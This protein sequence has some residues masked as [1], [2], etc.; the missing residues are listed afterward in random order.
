MTPTQWRR[1]Q[2]AVD[3][4]IV[5]PNMDQTT[6]YA[7]WRSNA[8]QD[9]VRSAQRLD[10]AA[11]TA[12]GQALATSNGAAKAAL[13]AKAARFKEAR[14]RLMAEVEPYRPDMAKLSAETQA[15]ELQRHQAATDFNSPW[16]QQSRALI[17]A[18]RAG[19][20]KEG[21]AQQAARKAEAAAQI[22]AGIPTKPTSS[23]AMGNLEQRKKEF[24]FRVD[25]ARGRMPEAVRRVFDMK[26]DVLK[27]A[28]V[29]DEDFTGEIPGTVPQSQY[30]AAKRA[31]MLIG[32]K[33]GVTGEMLEGG[34]APATGQP[35]PAAP[36]PTAT[37]PSATSKTAGPTIDEYVNL[38]EEDK[39][40]ADQDLADRL[41][42]ATDPDELDALLE[43]AAARGING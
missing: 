15:A 11:A 25:Q 32:Q 33:Y 37:V 9:K 7:A 16:N 38:S 19:Y 21:A 14:D 31:A 17:D 23:A 13:A 8:I 2:D 34:M 22:P 28:V 29:P 18:A 12:E 40:K 39:E 3:R 20:E 35:A 24:A 5:P 41:Q 1:G 43:E 10:Q 4:G 42:A 36:G 27:K 30:D 6:K 26:L